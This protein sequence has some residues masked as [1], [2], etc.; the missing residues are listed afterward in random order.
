MGTAESGSGDPHAWFA[1]YAPAAPYTLANGQVIQTPQ[2]AIAVQVEFAG[3]GS[4]VAAPIFR[5][6]VELYYNIA[7]LAPY[8]W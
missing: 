1:G 2:I 4:A 3:E 5:R 6:I 7:P 8:P